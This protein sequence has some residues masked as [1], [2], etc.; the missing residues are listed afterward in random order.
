MENSF[1]ACRRHSN[2][3]G[4]KDNVG[5]MDEASLMDEACFSFLRWGK[6]F[7][8]SMTV[9]LTLNILMRILLKKWKK[10][11]NTILDVLGILDISIIKIK[12]EIYTYKHQTI[13]WERNKN[14]IIL[15]K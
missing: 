11:N 8:S 7:S 4:L 5:L 15:L 12:K 9:S 13:T 1:S 2:E 3:A 6:F 10:T 14:Y